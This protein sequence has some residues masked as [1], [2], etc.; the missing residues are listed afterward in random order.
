MRSAEWEQHSADEGTVGLL[1]QTPLF[2]C[3]HFCSLHALYKISFME[4]S[5]SKPST[6][7]VFLSTFGSKYAL[8]ELIWIFYLK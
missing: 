6:T 2:P 3:K 8:T 7:S 4:M 5:L 1:S